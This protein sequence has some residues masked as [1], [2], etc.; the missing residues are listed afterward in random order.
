MSKST[1]SSV[2]GQLT[3]IMTGLCYLLACSSLALWSTGCA[4]TKT[5]VEFAPKPPSFAEKVSVETP[6]NVKKLKDVRGN[7]PFLLAQKGVAY[8]TSGSYVTARELSE[9]LTDT[10][11]EA[12]TGMGYKVTAEACDLTLGGEL[13]K[14]DSNAIMGFWSG[15]IETSVQMNLK[16]TDTKTGALAWNETISGFYKHGGIQI[17]NE[18]SRLKSANAA[19]ADL[20]KNLAASD[21]FKKVMQNYKK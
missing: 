11:R 10:L 4:F 2:S 9:I 3:K 8:K 21:T 18:T 19:V 14:F 1:K 6:V 15:D 12:L 7:D 17:D 16:L 5:T 13:V 20:M